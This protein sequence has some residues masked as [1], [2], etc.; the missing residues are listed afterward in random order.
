[1]CHSATIAS[2]KIP[3]TMLGFGGR[4]VAAQGIL[5]RERAGGNWKLAPAEIE[6]VCRERLAC[7]TDVERTSAA[8]TSQG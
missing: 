1:M 5:N 3:L 6:L 4:S 7:L 8:T 2:N